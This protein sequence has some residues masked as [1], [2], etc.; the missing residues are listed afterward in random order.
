MY[1]N[2]FVHFK[3][4]EQGGGTVYLWD[5]EK[6][7]LTFPTGEFNYAYVPDKTGG[8]TTIFGNLVKKTKRW[9][10]NA[11]TFESDVPMATRVLT[12]LYLDSDEVSTNHN[13]GIIDIEVD[14]ATGFPDP[15]RA[16]K[17]IT[18]IT[19]HCSKDDTYY[20]FSLDPEG[21]AD[22]ASIQSEFPNSVVRVFE[23]EKDM[24]KH[25]LSWYVEQEF[26]ILTGWNVDGFD[27]P[28]LHNRLLK[29]WAA[30][31]LLSPIKIV[32]RNE[33]QERFEVAG[34]SI[35]DYFQLYKKFRLKPRPNYR[36]GTIGEI[37]VNAPKKSYPGTL[38]EFRRDNLTEF[39]KY[40]IQDV[41]IVRD[42]DA[43]LKYIQLAQQVCHLSHVPYE[44]I[45]Y[46]SRFIEGVILTYLHRKGLVAPNKAADAREQME[47]REASKEK[48]FEGAYVKEPVIGLHEWVYSLDL[49]SLYPSIIMSL[50]ISPETKIAKVIDYDPEAQLKDTP[51]KYDLEV[52]GTTK[53]IKE[54]RLT[55]VLAKLNSSVASNGVMYS[56]DRV[57]IIPEILDVWFSKRKEYQRLKKEAAANGDE[58]QEDYY[59]R[60]Q[61]T[62]KVLL[63]SIYGV[64][65]LPSFRFYDLDN[66]EAVTTTGK[67]IAKE[68]GQFVQRF[69]EDVLG[70]EQDFVIY[71]D[72]DSC[73]LSAKPRGFE[74]I[75]WHTTD[76]WKTDTIALAR[77]V[78]G[79]LNEYYDV[80]ANKIFNIDSHRFLIRGESVANV[81]L[82]IDAKKMYSYR[83]VYNL[84]S[85]SDV[86]E[87]VT[88]GMPFIKSN[89]PPA[90]SRLMKT[91]VSKIL[92]GEPR[93]VIDKMIL[94]FFD[95]LPDYPVEDIARNTG[96]S[97]VNK[98]AA[99]TDSKGLL[100]FGKGTPIHIKACMTY[101]RFLEKNK[102][103]VMY[104]PIGNGEKIKYVYLVN[105]PHQ[106]NFIAFKGYDDPPE[107]V[108]FINTYVDRQKQYEAELQNKIVRIYDAMKWG[109]LPIR[110]NEVANEFFN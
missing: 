99:M 41:R 93:E 66:A 76:D 37:E 12:D 1:Q 75:P 54:G 83:L 21:R 67:T 33:H 96:A 43:K 58:A 39:I 110:S 59:D 60:L 68:S 48:G 26:T 51:K 86:D 16:E 36:L 62:Q 18:D 106:I 100:S 49:Q 38:A 23:S 20:I 81:G 90:F 53:H 94:D 105:N 11:V 15:S 29:K 84:E 98:F 14:S 103:N 89:F 97:N 109:N 24:M 69:Y 77:D 88:K 30:G 70:V 73:Y 9:A 17:E 31:N 91:M 102:L 71:Q 104:P 8:F 61:G 28:Y 92:D 101:N 85:N 44:D 27:I 63:N 64:L 13:I 5:D 46:S 47:K 82:W 34:V 56:K 78:E 52:A 10:K 3:S 22:V 40:N 55:E 87:V 65:G 42:L 95:E 32:K 107:V 74:Q 19:V 57:G 35:L 72:T 25:F 79:R 45:L 7:M 4:R 50:N 80:L 6:G 2:I 108:E